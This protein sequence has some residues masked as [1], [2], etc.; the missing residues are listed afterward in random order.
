MQESLIEAKR[1]GRVWPVDVTQ[2]VDEAWYLATYTD[3]AA[4]GVSAVE[5]YMS[6]GWAEGRNPGP[7]FDTEWYFRNYPDVEV[8]GMDPLTHYVLHGWR[9]RRNPHP[10]FDTGWYLDTYPDVAASGMNPLLHYL[11]SGR[12]EGR[13]PVRGAAESQPAS[14]EKKAAAPE[15]KPAAAQSEAAPAPPQLTPPPSV[16]EQAFISPHPDRDA[17]LELFDEEFYLSGFA[18]AERP[19]DP[20]SHFL[21][22]GWKEGRNPT[23]WFS[24]WHYQS[25]HP[26]VAQSGINPFLHYCIAG[27]NEGR[28]LAIMGA[29]S[30]SST[31]HAQAFAVS[32]GPHFEEFDP[33]IGAGREK[34][35]KV[36]AYYLPQFH[37]IE[38]NDKQWGKGFTEWR[39][40][41]RAMPR[42]K[43]HIQPRI[44]RDLGCYDLAESDVMRR[45]IEMAKAA[46]LHGF[47]FYH[48][49][50]DGK[51][52]LETPM[53]RFLAD[54]TL[55][56]P[57]C[58]MWAN[59]NW[60]RTW[61][62]SEKEMILAQT[63]LEEDDIPFI[64]DVARHMKDRRYIRIGDR[65][66][67]FIYRPGHIPDTV[68]RMEK[69]RNI[70]RE[71]HGLD[72][73]I[74]Q[75]QAF[76]DNDPREFGLD[77]A[78]EFP[79]H[80]VLN[81]V[82][83]IK[84][85]V[86]LF[87]ARF[88]G[89][90]P[91]YESIVEAAKS[92]PK[93]DFPLIRTVFPSWDNDARRPGRSTIT[94]YSTPE[95][96]SDWLE[97]A[98]QQAETAPVHGEPFVC[99][100]A[101]NEW[102]E[103]AY[104]EPDVHY[105]SAYLNSLS[106]VVFK[107]EE[108]TEL[109]AEPLTVPAKQQ[110]LLVGHDTFAFGAQKLLCHIGSTLKNNFGIE[111]SFLIL[112]SYTLDGSHVTVTETMEQIGPVT[113]ADTFEGS[114]ADLA[115]SLKEQGFSIAIT[116]TTVAG[117]IVRDLKEAGLNT[118]SL[119][120][121]LPNL[122]R[123]A[124]LAQDARE[125]AQHSDYAIFPAEVVRD[126]FEAVAGLR[127]KNPQI[128]PQGLYNTSVIEM[129]RGD[130][131]VRAELGL[132]PDTRIVLGV[133][134][135]DLRKGIDR[136][137]S[138]GLSLCSVREDVAFIWAGAP[139]G[140]ASNWFLP[141]IDTTGLA[142][143]V[144]IIGHRDDVAR[145][146]AAADAFYLSSREDPFPS[147]V[148]E[149][150]ACGLPVVGHEGCGGCD[151]LIRQHGVLLAPDNPNGAATAFNELIDTPRAADNEA[152]RQ[153]IIRSFHFPSYVFGLAQRLIPGLPAVSAAV[154]NY[155]YEAYIGPRLQ[156]VFDQDIPLKEVI[157][158]D[159]ASPDNSI[160]VIRQ[161]AEA[162][163]RQIDLHVNAQ[164]TGSAFRQWRKAAELARGDYLWIA[165]ADD[166]ADP[167]FVSRLVARMQRD[168]SVLGFTDSRQIDETGAPTGD[169][170]VPY[171]NE[172]EPNA[173]N[174][175]FAMDGRDFLARF[176]SV[177]NVILNV[178]GVIFRRDALLAAF[179]SVGE[180]LY[181]YSVAG[182]WRLYAEICAQPGARISW[183]AEPLN[184]HRRHKVSVTHAL[185][186]DKHLGEIASMHAYTG[187]QVDLP[188]YRRDMQRQHLE[189]CERHLKSQ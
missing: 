156:S 173:F 31:Y 78:I 136:F 37:P 88:S 121:E 15:K 24:V 28:S 170:Y 66:L 35:A 138:A 143:R 102:A 10:Q 97:W 149:A 129:P 17:I 165:E 76:G 139:S 133:G 70:F 87:D 53:E 40:L 150:L 19:A 86:G 163:G 12:N 33:S 68:D 189:A 1:S 2:L 4:A 158:L 7:L 21:E 32:P 184:T 62:G 111:V 167:A 105:G 131:G 55:D 64:D 51:R 130:H 152:K 164:N 57:I 124:G 84:H 172:A 71:R 112:S 108:S 166:L 148:L 18:E 146:F 52:V 45:Q 83:D 99:I 63:Y 22:K 60:T 155:K 20:A 94:A 3:V 59:E 75:A 137:V 114:Q 128:F 174:A 115:R 5:H 42:F 109:P 110:I 141:E 9:Q 77:G 29:G 125:I 6:I 161:T 67:F 183:L 159:D 39:Q 69:W 106:R 180:E 56:F 61:D 81:K 73:L 160:A 80:K 36:L 127:P 14:A 182:D 178:S 179:D 48:Y 135:A 134:Y 119:I 34:R 122:L 162:A 30:D 44:P 58:L 154:P 74:F 140:E 41:A 49:W 72:P 157:V 38:V 96:F 188:P 185:K 116:N 13:L 98:V 101:W 151:D 118:V 120:H 117:R 126:G 104:L 153:E 26:D 50:F 175:S 169:S 92:D 82:H 187:K 113:F 132:S 90:V 25:M 65:P 181:G 95:L 123:S 27:A 176:L 107:R 8:T 168:G 186:V 23:P 16:T 145:F 93:P 85:K 43:G 89:S 171:I 142:K 177:K 47:C 100:N 54:P 46:G 11:Q 103:G 91:T 79:P 147:V 144:R